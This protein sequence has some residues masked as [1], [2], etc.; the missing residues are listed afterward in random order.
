MIGRTRIEGRADA[1]QRNEI[2]TT[3]PKSLNSLVAEAADAAD[4]KIDSFYTGQEKKTFEAGS[5][6][7]S[8]S[9]L[10]GP[11]QDLGLTVAHV[12]SESFG[13]QVV[14]ELLAD[15][16][17]DGLI[18]YDAEMMAQPEAVARLAA[19][20]DRTEDKILMG[21]ARR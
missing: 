4:A 1:K 6:R 7:G 18:A 9:A 13:R 17:E 10:A 14:K 15:A 8:R 3:P 12:I 19:I 11:L 16:G 2:A 5:R 20:R 21:A